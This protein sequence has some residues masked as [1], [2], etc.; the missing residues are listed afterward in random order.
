MLYQSGRKYHFEVYTKHIR[1][2]KRVIQTAKDQAGKAVSPIKCLASAE[3]PLMARLL[4]FSVLLYSSCIMY[5]GTTRVQLLFDRATFDPLFYAL[6]AV[7]RS[8]IYCTIPL[9][10]SMEFV[11]CAFAPRISFQEVNY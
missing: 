8:W 4:S 6:A 11:V 10:R 7:L 9:K 5:C 3:S 2:D 1:T